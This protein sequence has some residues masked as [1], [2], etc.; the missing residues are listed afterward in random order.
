[1]PRLIHLNG[2]S[3]VGKST[4]AR[5]YADEHPGTLVLD[6]D[7]L[8]GLIGG[9]S[10]NFSGALEIARG[11]GREMAA[12]HL[13]DGYD[14]V[15]PQLVTVHDRA[16]DPALE[17]TAAASGAAYTEVALMVGHLEHLQRL[18]AK[19]PAN[20]VEEQI[21]AALTDPSS[22]LVERIHGHL[23]EYLA[24]RPHAMRIDTTHLTENAAY[25]RLREELAAC[26][27]VS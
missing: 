2:P 9:W 7:V 16:P 23:A 18:R 6:L 5:R 10:D 25:V 11:L 22:D 1:M 21:Q 17:R 26:E 15:F 3:R 24:Q 19:R 20:T 8:A 27:G 14:V 13:R 12:R 4:R